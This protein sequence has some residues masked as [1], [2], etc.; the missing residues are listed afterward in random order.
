MNQ[1]PEHR[2]DSGNAIE[3]TGIGQHLSPS[4]R[5]GLFELLAQ[6]VS[7]A[8][9]QSPEQQRESFTL[10]LEKIRSF[11]IRG[12][13]NDGARCAAC[14][15]A[16]LNDC[17]A[18]NN[19]ILPKLLKQSKSTI[20]SR[21]K[22][23]GYSKAAL[24]AEVASQLMNLFPSMRVS[25]PFMKQWSVRRRVGDDHDHDNGVLDFVNFE[26]MQDGCDSDQF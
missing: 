11:V 4:D 9:Q 21:F 2:L 15:V 7:H 1:N 19:Q 14:G 6:I 16:W 12:D 13:G 26:E 22:L 8:R 23:L 10:N 3:S 18:V 20:N 5:A 17:I 24:T 25:S